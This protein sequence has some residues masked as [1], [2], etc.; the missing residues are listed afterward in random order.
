MISSRNLQLVSQKIRSS[1]FG[2]AFPLRYATNSAYRFIHADIL[3]VV[4]FAE[5]AQ[6][7]EFRDTCQEHETQ[8]GSHALRGCRNS[9]L[10]SEAWAGSSLHASHREAGRH[11]CLSKQQPA[12]GL[13]ISTSYK[14]LQ[15]LIAF[16]SPSSLP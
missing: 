14:T 1:T 16:I 13:S 10:R 7:R 6:L 5:D 2:S 15:A 12:A 9:A 3:D 4:H 11:I 8:I